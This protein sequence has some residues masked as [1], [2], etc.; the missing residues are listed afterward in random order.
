MPSFIFKLT[1]QWKWNFSQ[2]L[3]NRLLRTNL[4][5]VKPLLPQNSFIIETPRPCKTNHSLTNI[6]QGNTVS[7]RTDEQNLWDKKGT[8]IKQ[9]YLPQSYN[10]LKEL[11]GMNYK[12]FNT[13]QREIYQEI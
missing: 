7:T 9:N 2:K 3:F 4:P 8:I 5:L 13:D 11:T 10:V 6:S 12:T 1:T